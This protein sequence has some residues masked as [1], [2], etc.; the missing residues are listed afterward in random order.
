MLRLTLTGAVSADSF[1]QLAEFAAWLQAAGFL[2]QEV[3]DQV[4]CLEELHG[5]LQAL[6]DRDEVIAGV[7]ADLIRL[8]TLDNPGK[9][10]PAAVEARSVDELMKV[11]QALEQ[12]LAEWSGGGRT[13]SRAEVAEAG[14]QM[15]AT[16]VGE[17]E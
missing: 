3:R 13:L 4:R 14:L 10:S 16:P 5:A 8:A 2:Q 11:W 9:A 15:L 17:V 7:A 6:A 12:G 1:P